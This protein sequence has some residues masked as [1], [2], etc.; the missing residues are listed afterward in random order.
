MRSQQEMNRAPPQCVS[1]ALP[2]G[3]G[4]HFPRSGSPK[5][6][7]SLFLSAG[8]SPGGPRQ[9]A[10]P[11]VGPLYPPCARHISKGLRACGGLAQKHSGDCPW[12]RASRVKAG[13]GG[14]GVMA[15]LLEEMGG[16]GAVVGAESETGHCCGSSTA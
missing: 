16:G 4:T 3:S 2:S 9:L 1:L 11:L 7:C 13:T 15:N 12:I 8:L 10:R 5:A 14:A 6:I